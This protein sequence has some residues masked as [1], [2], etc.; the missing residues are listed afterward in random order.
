MILF[1]WSSFIFNDALESL[2]KAF[3]GLMYGCHVNWLQPY[4]LY[5]ASSYLLIARL[6]A[7]TL[8][9]LLGNVRHISAPLHFV[10]MKMV[11][12]VCKSCSVRCVI[13][14]REFVWNGK[15]A[16]WVRDLL[17][18]SVSRQI[19]IYYWI[20]YFISRHAV[21]WEQVLRNKN[22]PGIVNERLCV[23]MQINDKKSKWI[24]CF[25][26]TKARL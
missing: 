1:Y 8:H 3:D 10:S 12:I 17:L 2:S 4:T 6:T 18:F 15:V 14:Q 23:V 20:N 22:R 25:F 7:R 11:S 5:P 24:A 16:V 26:T 13:T 19:I 9:C 21:V